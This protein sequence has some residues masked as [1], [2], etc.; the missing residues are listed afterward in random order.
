VLSVKSKA[1]EILTK[2]Q[3]GGLA[4]KK[5][6]VFMLIGCLALLVS[7]SIFAAAGT[8]GTTQDWSTVPQ[9]TVN[10]SAYVGPYASITF[11]SASPL[12]FVGTPGET[13]SSE[14]AYV[15]DTNCDVVA[16][17]LGTSFSGNTYGDIL[18]TQYRCVD[19]SDF[20]YQDWTDAGQINYDAFDAPFGVNTYHL[21]YKATLGSSAISAQRAGNYSAHYTIIVWSPHNMN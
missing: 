18:A 15:V 20:N 6:M 1:H 17:G 21:E 19:P 14:V 2:I 12:T 5:L 4:M 13:Q 10:L 9:D 3:I 11:S 16:D 8:V 7:G